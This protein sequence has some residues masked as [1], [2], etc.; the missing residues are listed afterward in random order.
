MLILTLFSFEDKDP[1]FTRLKPGLAL[2][3]LSKGLF[4][5]RAM[6]QGNTYYDCITVTNSGGTEKEDIV[7][8]CPN[9]VH[10]NKTY[11]EGQNINCPT[12]KCSGCE[13][14]LK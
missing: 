6:F 9:M 2:R 7:P 1:R 5:I 10:E 14:I 8:W 11:I 13:F 4:Y 3:L 12:P